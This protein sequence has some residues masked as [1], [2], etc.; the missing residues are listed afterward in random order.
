[1]SNLSTVLAVLLPVFCLALALSIGVITMRKSGNAKR[2]FARHFLTLAVALTLSLGGVCFASAVGT[3]ATA[4]DNSAETT[5]TSAQTE[6]KSD[7]GAGLAAGLGFIGSGLSIGLAAVGA[8]VAL[9]SGAPAA[10]GAVAEDPKS[11]G[12]SMIF[13]ALGEAVAIYGFIIAFL[14]ILRLPSGIT[15]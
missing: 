1:M 14:I 15:L 11:F 5:A 2:A 10:I 13:V 7:K 6:E 8:G 3:D 9:A 12:K 4:N